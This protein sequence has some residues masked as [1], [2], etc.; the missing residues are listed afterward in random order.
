MNFL[1]YRTPLKCSDYNGKNSPNNSIDILNALL[2]K[3]DEHYIYASFYYPD[4]KTTTRQGFM[5]FKAQIN[6]VHILKGEVAKNNQI[7]LWKAGKNTLAMKQEVKNGT[8]KYHVI[9]KTL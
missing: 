3:T 6:E 5:E 4:N 9:L 2:L 8:T 1:N 7:G